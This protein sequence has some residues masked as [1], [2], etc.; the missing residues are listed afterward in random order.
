MRVLHIGKFFPPFAGGM[1]NFLAELLPALQ[2]QSIS[3]AALVH[4]HTG[5]EGSIE[6]YHE[7]PIYRAPCY[8]RLL[9]APVSP[10]F[11][12]WLK[13]AIRDFQ[14]DCLHLH[15]PNTSAFYCLMNTYARRL[16]WLVHWH[17]DVVAS[18]LDKRLAL[19]YRGYRPLEQKLLARSQAIIVTSP[20]YL[21]ASAALA[22]WRERCHVVPL[23]LSEHYLQP[24]ASALQA[25]EQLWPA[26]TL[27]LLC[28]GRLTYY[29]G[30]EVLLQALKDCP[31]TSLLVAG[32]GERRAVLQ[33]K[34]Q[35]LGLSQ[36][37][38]LLG[39]TEPDL[40]AALLASCDVL[41]LPSLERT[42]AFG[43]VLLEAMRAGKAVI[44]SDIPG[45]GTGWV[46]RSSQS[47]ITVPVG[48]PQALA[49]AIQ[50][51]KNTAVREH[52]ANNGQ[53]AFNRLFRI[54]QIAQ[55]VAPLYA[56]TVTTAQTRQ[57]EQS[58]KISD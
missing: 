5:S 26:Q 13:R 29:K 38:K 7:I 24:T 41:C 22:P 32:G 19:A 37:A 28:I 21:A 12:R 4:N 10:G 44:A 51:L 18:A 11:G 35:S 27:R 20:D 17:S 47:G 49:K 56:D 50:S 34:I 31:K 3:C 14:P 43:M 55:Q 16:P 52:Y 48:Q 8:G 53:Q 42:E 2:T 39:Y 57:A 36:R 6:Q 1:E 15:L 45:S 33:D 23:G 30:Q 46:V 9:Y 58:V 40:L 54:E 25:T